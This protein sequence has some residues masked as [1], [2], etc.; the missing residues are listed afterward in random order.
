MGTILSDFIKKGTIDEDIILKYKDKLP[1]ELI[2]VWEKY[3][4]GTFVNGFIKIINPDD[5]LDILE[6]SYLRYEQAIPIF[7]TAM[8]D[9]IVWEKGKYANLINYRK[10]YVNVVSSGF[11]FFFDDLKDPDFMNDELMWQPYPDAIRTYS[12]PDYDECF[13]Y[14]PLL[15][16]GG[17]EKVENLS[18]VKLKEHILVITEFM[19]PVQ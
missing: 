7:A 5:Y 19:G 8:G 10:G 1:K 12:A 15:G 2:G 17:N 4:Y 13:G 6:R 11:E 3:G 14:T 9:L 16:L 18:K